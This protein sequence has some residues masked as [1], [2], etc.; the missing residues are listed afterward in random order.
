MIETILGAPLNDAAQHAITS[1]NEVPPAFID[2]ARPLPPVLRQMFLRFYVAPSEYDFLPLFIE[3]VVD[4]GAD[5]AIWRKGRFLIPFPPIE[6]MLTLDVTSLL[7]LVGR[8]AAP[9][10]W[11]RM[12]G[13]LEAWKAGDTTLGAPGVLRHDLDYHY[14]PPLNVL[15]FL[16]DRPLALGDIGDLEIAVRRW[17][18]LRMA[19][20][21]LRIGVAPHGAP[22]ELLSEVFPSSRVSSDA[23]IAVGALIRETDQYEDDGIPG[24]RG[25]D[26]WYRGK[27]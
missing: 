13:S 12:A 21:L 14:S 19:R 16:I 11:K 15:D 7:A 25:P 24:F 22:V 26:D 18:A 10:S 9:A 6:E 8:G 20:H 17:M 5:P 3:E 2:A 1:L 4:R 23:T 27:R